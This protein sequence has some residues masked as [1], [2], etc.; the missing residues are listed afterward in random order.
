[1]VPGS[2]GMP[3]AR[4]EAMTGLRPGEYYVVAVDDLEPDDYR[5]PA[6]LDR[7]RSSAM[8]VTIPDGSTVDVPLRRASFADIMATR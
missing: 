5:D 4:R 3:P 2:I 6:V 8:R 1:M 7:L